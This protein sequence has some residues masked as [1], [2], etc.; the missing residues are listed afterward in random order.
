MKILEDGNYKSIL[1][2]E[3]CPIKP[4]PSDPDH[5]TVD[6]FQCTLQKFRNVSMIY[7]I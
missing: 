6:W 5:K 7:Y 3:M 1:K 4:I 2:A